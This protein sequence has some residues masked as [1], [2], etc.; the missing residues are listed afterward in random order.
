DLGPRSR[1]I[2]ASA[3]AWHPRESFY[4]AIARLSRYEVIRTPPTWSLELRLGHL[5]SA[6]HDVAGEVQATHIIIEMP[7]A[8][9]VYSRGRQRQRTKG[10][11]N[12]AALAKLHAAVGALVAGAVRHSSDVELV[13]ASRTPKPTRLLAVRR[14]LTSQHHPIMDRARVSPDLLDAISVG[15]LWLTHPL[16]WKDCAA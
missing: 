8:P 15:A 16:R 1:M 5:S 4:D 3:V 7:A 14:T 9:S 6:I 2:G 13:P 10:A 11:I 12:G